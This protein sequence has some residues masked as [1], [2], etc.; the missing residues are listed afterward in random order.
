[1]WISMLEFYTPNKTNCILL[2]SPKIWVICHTMSAISGGSSV[3]RTFGHTGSSNVFWH[4]CIS[5]SDDISEDYS[6][7]GNLLTLRMTR[8]D[9]S[10]F[11]LNSS[12]KI[13]LELS[14][15]PTFNFN[16]LH[17]APEGETCLILFGFQQEFQH[18]MNSHGIGFQKI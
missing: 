10:Q 17:T 8:A 3:T 15:L 2:W 14:K 1:M 5:R 7:S 11:Q 16:T 9:A 4:K 13:W 6:F 18:H 12:L